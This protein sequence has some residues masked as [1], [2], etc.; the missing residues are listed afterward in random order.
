MLEVVWK[1]PETSLLT[2]TDDVVP[3][4]RSL[5]SF[6]KKGELPFAFNAFQKVLR[7][8]ESK[9]GLDVN[10]GYIEWFVKFNVE[11]R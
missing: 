11:N 4:C 2:C 6:F 3:L 10:I 9:R 8:T 5:M 1:E 7:S